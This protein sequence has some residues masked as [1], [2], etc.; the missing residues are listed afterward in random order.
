MT[1]LLT[2]RQWPHPRVDTYVIGLA[3]LKILRVSA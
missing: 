2:V 3:S 1:V